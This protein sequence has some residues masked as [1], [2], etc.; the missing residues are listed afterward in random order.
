MNDAIRIESLFATPFAVV[1][2]GANHDFNAR[3]VTLCESQRESHPSRTREPYF[4]GPDDFL[5]HPDAVELK[6]GMLGQAAAIVSRLSDVDA[7]EFARLQA[8]ARGW[9]AIVP[10]DGH[11]PAQHFPGASWLATYCVQSGGVDAG[12]RGAGVVRLYEKRLASIYRD[13]STRALKAPYRYGNHTWSPVPGWM[14]MFPA[15]VPHEVSVVRSDASLILVFAMIRF[16][17]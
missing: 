8:Q 3:L 10:R 11:V 9:C 2:I 14:T 12:H 16:L 6:R 4:R 13:A 17:E 1:N 5:D 15:H 7:A